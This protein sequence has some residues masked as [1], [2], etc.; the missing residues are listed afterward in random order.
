MQVAFNA[1]SGESLPVRLRGKD[2]FMKGGKSI[3]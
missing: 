1:L 2:F 3:G